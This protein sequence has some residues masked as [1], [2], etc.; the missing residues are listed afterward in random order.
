MRWNLVAL[1]SGRRFC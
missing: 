1:F